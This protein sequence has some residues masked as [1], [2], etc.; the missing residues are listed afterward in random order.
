MT[1]GIGTVMEAKMIILLASG[2]NKK[3]AV[4]Q[5][6]E[7]PVTASVPASVLQLHPQAKIIVDEDSGTLLSRKDY[8]TW[9]YQNKGRV[10]DYLK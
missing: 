7:G 5:C 3:D 9:V 4:R 6:V 10:K 8:Y 1:M 2:D